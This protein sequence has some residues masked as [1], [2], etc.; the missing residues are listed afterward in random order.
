MGLAASQARFL[1]ITARRADCEFKSLQLAQQKMSIG[2][3]LSNASDEYETA[4]NATKLVW[5]AT[6]GGDSILGTTSGTVT[7]LNY[8]VL[9][10][11]S[12]YN[13]Y[14]PY[15]LTNPH[16]EIILTEK[17]AEAARVISPNGSAVAPSS[18]GYLQFVKKLYENGVI[19]PTTWS[20]MGSIRV[21]WQ[22]PSD[23]S[24]SFISRVSIEDASQASIMTLPIMQF[25]RFTLGTSPTFEEF[26]IRNNY[27]SSAGLGGAQYDK[28][29]SLGVDIYGLI[30]ELSALSDPE[31]ENSDPIYNIDLTNTNIKKYLVGSEHNDSAGTTSLGDILGK[32]YAVK[33][34]D[35]TSATKV[36]NY[37][38]SKLQAM[39]KLLGLEFDND[40]NV[41]YDEPASHN[42]KG[43][44]VDSE[45]YNALVNAYLNTIKNYSKAQ[46]EHKNGDPKMYNGF[47]YDS[48]DSDGKGYE[49]SLTNMLKVFLTN[50]AKT[51]D[52]WADG[53][54]V[55]D[56]SSS[57]KFVT[58]DSSYY[59][60]LD[61]SGSVIDNEA[62][63]YNDFYSQLYNQICTN[64]WVDNSTYNVDNAQ[65]LENE[66]KNG[67]IFVSS[68]N[69][70]GYF[71]Q[72]A[73]AD[74]EYIVA[75][76]DE[77]AIA[78][79][80]AKYNSLKAKLDNKEEDLDLQIKTLDLEI[81]AI[82]TEYDT[83]KNLINKNIDKTFNM[84]SS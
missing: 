12:V 14:N 27:N 57:S 3:E 71:Y 49:L 64:G 56:K 15:L 28:T 46:S 39:A 77:D 25:A 41:I 66:L 1:A 78:R 55:N 23:T 8:D 81:A 24:Q 2:R 19:A 38:K 79:A 31:D 72:S 80:E 13:A 67:Q 11:P 47:Y 26:K 51:L 32:E 63:L 50:F 58:K 33:F 29:D 35:G 21:N 17:Y 4:L 82:N 44:Y 20:S 69:M 48:S 36:I 76:K 84:F 42:A 34:K 68:L 30:S 22:N 45:S 7:S 9:M 43:L 61:N 40:G 59:Y 53:Y 60:I 75:V 52:G 74:T 73:Y 6:G 83:V 37:S 16:G 18:A 54:S 70:D 65:Y 5:D 62:L 10:Q